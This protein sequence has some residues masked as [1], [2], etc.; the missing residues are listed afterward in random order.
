MEYLLFA[1][2]REAND[3]N[4]RFKLF[5]DYLGSYKDPK[6]AAEEMKR[7]QE[8]GSDEQSSS[9]IIYTNANYG[10]EPELIVKLSSEEEKREFETEFDKAMKKTFG[11]G[12]KETKISIPPGSNDESISEEESDEIIVN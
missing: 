6:R 2:D 7:S 1:N 10:K 12:Y 8:L 5:A 11:E 4:I 3:D 9:Q